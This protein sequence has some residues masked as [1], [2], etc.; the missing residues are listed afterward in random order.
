M[1]PSLPDIV[2]ATAVP[3]YALDERVHGSVRCEACDKVLKKLTVRQHVAKT[4]P[5]RHQLTPDFVSYI[6]KVHRTAMKLYMRHRSAALRLEKKALKPVCRRSQLS[7]STSAFSPQPS[8]ISSVTPTS[9]QRADLGILHL[10]H[11]NIPL[12]APQHV[13]AASSIFKKK[14]TASAT[15]SRPFPVLPDLPAPAAVKKHSVHPAV[16]ALPILPALPARSVPSPPPALSKPPPS[17][18]TDLP[19]RKAWQRDFGTCLGLKAQQA[20][21]AQAQTQRLSGQQSN[22]CLQRLLQSHQIEHS[23]VTARDQPRTNLA[24]RSLVKPPVSSCWPTADFFDIHPSAVAG[25]VRAH[26]AQCPVPLP[27]LPPSI[28]EAYVVIDI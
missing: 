21:Q 18:G 16:R 13:N 25:A 7:Q 10:L 27:P 20:Q 8:T 26:A 22:P 19:P 28:S 5:L 23:H 15:P 1:A 3:A 2:G 14:K 6:F 4:C 12:S 17:P 11:R 9:S 24:R